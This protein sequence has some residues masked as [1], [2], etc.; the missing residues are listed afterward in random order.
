MW[1]DRL[2]WGDAMLGLEDGDDVLYGDRLVWG[3]RLAWGDLGEYVLSDG[4]AAQSVDP[5]LGSSAPTAT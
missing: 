5:E 1:G 4:A 3:D 2:V